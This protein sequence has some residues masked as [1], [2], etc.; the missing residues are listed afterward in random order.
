MTKPSYQDY[1]NHALRFYVRNPALNMRSPGL[2][3]SDI[4]NW[5]ACNNALRTF[6]EQDRSVIVGVYNSK[7]TM[8]DAVK[9]IS[10][11]LHLEEANVWQLLGRATKEFA[12]CRGLI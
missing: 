12:R 9:G 3:K 10:S 2:K 11:Q 7:C 5:M 1:A 6:T 8:E 4:Q